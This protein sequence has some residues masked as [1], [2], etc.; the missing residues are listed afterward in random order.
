MTLYKT[1]SGENFPKT[2]LVIRKED[3]PEHIVPFNVLYLFGELRLSKGAIQASHLPF[4]KGGQQRITQTIEDF[5]YCFYKWPGKLLGA[6]LGDILE[7]TDL[8]P[9]PCHAHCP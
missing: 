6:E 7:P 5:G 9:H 3:T 8:P 2:Y 1:Y 4:A